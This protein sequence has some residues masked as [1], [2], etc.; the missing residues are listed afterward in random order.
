MKY[1]A[2]GVADVT[3]RLVA[4]A[5]SE[6][7]GQNF[8]IENMPGAGSIRGDCRGTLTGGTTATR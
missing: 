3:A 4:Q 7:L 5:L 2:G 1:G 8:I 6:K